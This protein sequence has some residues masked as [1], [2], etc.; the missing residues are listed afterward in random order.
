VVVKAVRRSGL[1]GIGVSRVAFGCVGCIRML[2][3]CGSVC[4]VL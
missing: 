1:S 3:Q 4:V 2:R